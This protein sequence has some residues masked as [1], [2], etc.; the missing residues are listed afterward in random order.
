MGKSYSIG[1]DL[2]K[3]LFERAAFIIQGI[4]LSI[5]VQGP[6]ISMYASAPWIM[7]IWCETF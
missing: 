1:N 4:A 5:H 2:Q 7:Q 3:R 6:A